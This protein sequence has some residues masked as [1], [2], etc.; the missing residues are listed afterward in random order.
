MR[1]GAGR[2]GRTEARKKVTWRPGRWVMRETRRSLTLS[3]E[4]VIYLKKIVVTFFKM[5]GATGTTGLIETR[6]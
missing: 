5:S 1:G 3:A 4:N 6:F 2:G